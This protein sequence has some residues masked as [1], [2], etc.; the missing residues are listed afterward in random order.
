MPGLTSLTSPFSLAATL[1]RH[2]MIL[3]GCWLWLFASSL[4][5]LSAE[6][7]V[8]AQGGAAL[9]FVSVVG[10]P[11][12]GEQTLAAALSK[13]LAGLGMKPASAPAVGVYEVEGIV[14]VTK[15]N[16]GK[17][18]VRIDWTVFD[19]EGNTLG[20]ISQ[21]NLV[22]QGSL[23]QRWGAAAEGAANAAMDGLAKLLPRQSP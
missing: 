16:G 5:A 3:A 17:Q 18:S 10:A 13:R 8:Q 9:A 2:A 14:R 11:G 1:M 21:T 15:A 23:D 19:P 22:R 12:D 6:N 20:N 4:Q 7:G